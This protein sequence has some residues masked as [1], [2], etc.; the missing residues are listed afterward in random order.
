VTGSGGTVSF[1]VTRLVSPAL[2]G[3]HSATVQVEAD[4]HQ[5]SRSFA[6]VGLPDA[7]VQESRERVRAGIAN[8]AFEVP[9]QR[10]V[11]NLAPADLRKMGPQYDLPIALAVLAAAG[12]LSPRRLQG[13]GAVGEL[14]LDGSLRAVPG[15]LAMAEHAARS[16]WRRLVVPAVN[17]AEASLVRNV[18]IVPVRDLR[19][20]VEVLE[21]REE[22]VVPSIDID[23]LIATDTASGCDLGEVRGQQAARRALEI[24]A[25][26]G[27][28]LLM[29][30][31]PGGGKTMLARRLPGIL[32]RLS[33]DDAITVTR[34]H[35]VAG[36][37]PSGSV[38][39]VT[40]PFRSPH[41]TISSVGLVGG[42]QVPRPGEVTLAHL[43]VLFLDEVCAFAPAALD[44][45]RQPIEEGWI[46]VTRG[47]V[48][49]RFPARPII[50][51][52]GNPCPC[53]FDGDPLTPC[54]CPPGRATAYRARLSGPVADR[55]DLQITV[56]RL[57]AGEVVGGGPSGEPSAA[58]RAR[59]EAARTVAAER[60]QAGPNATLGAAAVRDACRL[61]EAGRLLLTRAVDRFALTARG[62]DRLLRVART[63]ADLA[64]EDRVI[65]DHLAEA[66]QYRTSGFVGAA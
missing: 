16:G 59:V 19:H 65:A 33:V 42:G 10:I 47:M 23:A 4:L 39:R 48:T 6:I 37:L 30:G 62:H 36:L 11:V 3:L 58:V 51:C 26:G 21:G 45:L 28:S 13:V 54:S 64:G 49:A 44:A 66:L 24:A 27:H 14:A 29:T 52:A 53:G 15:A 17:A 50:V 35:S 60:G 46:D 9:K 8:Q 25:A 32:P 41:H 20:A 38:G 43:G 57:D 1:V 40:R 12:Q 7:A 55:I 31:P 2:I 56:P 5:G 63:I 34:I 18:E 61:D 22:V